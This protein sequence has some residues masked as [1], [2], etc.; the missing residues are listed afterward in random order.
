[1]EATLFLNNNNFAPIFLIP[2]ETAC[3]SPPHRRT[4][5]S[6]L[7]LEKGALQSGD[8][9]TF[10]AFLFVLSSP[11]IHSLS[12]SFFSFREKLPISAAFWPLLLHC[13]WVVV[14]AR[15]RERG[16]EKRHTMGTHTR[17]NYCMT[18][19]YCLKHV[20]FNTVKSIA[21]T[22]SQNLIHL[23]STA[24]EANKNA[25]S[26]T[27]IVWWGMKKGD[28]LSSLP[29][30]KR[31]SSGRERVGKGR[32]YLFFH[33]SSSLQTRK[34]PGLPPCKRDREEWICIR[35]KRDIHLLSRSPEGGFFSCLG[36]TSSSQCLNNKLESKML[37]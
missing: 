7:P 19:Q 31:P 18:L 36:L 17:P 25:I 16:V 24:Y 3:F 23:Y 37:D 5:A 34:S 13:G 6:L 20:R 21:H 11:H 35:Y 29:M 28:K 27:E 1:M 33:S 4:R 10:L 2:K 12:S 9:D 26:G 30:R 14:V 32:P 22:Q 15:S 8:S